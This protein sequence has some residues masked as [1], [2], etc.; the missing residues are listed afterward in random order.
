[1]FFD[2]YDKAVNARHGLGAGLVT[3]VV[4]LFRTGG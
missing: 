2:F 1:M 4:P 3:E